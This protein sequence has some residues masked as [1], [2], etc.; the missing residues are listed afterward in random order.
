MRN[1]TILAVIV[2][3]AFLAMAAPTQAIFIETPLSLHTDDGQADVG[4]D[5]DFTIGPNQ[6]NES[7]AA[8]W[9]GKRVKVGY[10]YDKN[11]G[12]AAPD[13]DAPVSDEGY[14]EGTITEIELD[15]QARGAFTWRIPAEVDHKNVHVFLEDEAGERLAFSYLTIGDAQ[16]QMHAMSGPGEDQEAEPPGGETSEDDAAAEASGLVGLALLL[17]LGLAAL[18]AIAFRRR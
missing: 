2:A 12:G 5:V 17:A 11:E 14:T 13:P 16:P 6:N 18:G 7:A 8:G 4:D 1:P 10:S 15:E 9:A 3:A